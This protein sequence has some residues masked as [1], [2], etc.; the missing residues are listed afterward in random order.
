MPKYGEEGKNKKSLLEVKNKSIIHDINFNIDY[1]NSRLRK[2][3][4]DTALSNNFFDESL[5]PKNANLIDYRDS[6]IGH[7]DGVNNYYMNTGFSKI[8]TLM[9]S[10]NNNLIASTQKKSREVRES[11]IASIR[12]DQGVMI[13]QGD[14]IL[15][16]LTRLAVRFDSQYK[17]YFIQISEFYFYQDK[18]KALRLLGLVKVLI[19]FL[20]RLHYSMTPKQHQLVKF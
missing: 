12:V 2:F 13:D 11:S 3:W 1:Y 7:R 8:N 17:G 5:G 20:F 15:D 10:L 16:K 4:G 14:D 19:I 18:K 9:I 6:F